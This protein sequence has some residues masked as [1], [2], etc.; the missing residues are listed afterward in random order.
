MPSLNRVLL[1]GHLTRD[2]QT[3]QLPGGTT[4]AE[5]GLAM[6][7]KFKV[8]DEAREEVCFVD[9]SAFGKQAEVIA[10]YC[11]KGKALFVEGRLKLDSW[12]GKDGTKRSKLSVIVENFQFVGGPD[13]DP[14]RSET[15]SPQ[16]DKQPAWDPDS[17]FDSAK[18]G[19]DIPF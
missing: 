5:F 3:K 7:R 13:G 6:N 8:K 15:R 17:A 9:C 16:Q 10:Q 2:V 14:K 4:I 11:Q 19:D 1:I 18:G 12:E